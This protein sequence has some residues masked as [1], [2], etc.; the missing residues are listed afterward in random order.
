MNIFQVNLT[1]LRDGEGCS[2]PRGTEWSS[3][4]TFLRG[5][6]LSVS[7]VSICTLR[8]V[9]VERN[10]R[11]IL[12]FYSAIKVRAAYIYSAVVHTSSCLEFQGDW[13]LS[14]PL[15]V[16]TTIPVTMIQAEDRP[17]MA[18]R[19]FSSPVCLLSHPFL[20]GVTAFNK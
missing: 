16:K 14:E 19:T 4:R 7:Q 3:S 15:G 12:R 11:S 1:I 18:S 10:L 9:P 2:T 6:R 20:N 8:L 17:R 13:S 5:M